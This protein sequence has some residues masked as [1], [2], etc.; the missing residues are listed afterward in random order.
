MT[1]VWGDTRRGRLRTAY[2]SEAR[3]IDIA[4]SNGHSEIVEILLRMLCCC[5]FFVQI[6]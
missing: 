1:S 4:R 6:S 5:V 3:P 2:K